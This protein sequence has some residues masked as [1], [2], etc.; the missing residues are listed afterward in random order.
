[1]LFAGA[2]GKAWCEAARRLNADR[3]FELQCFCNGPDGDVRDLNNRWS[4]AYGV[5]Q[6]GAVLI[7]PDGFIAWRARVPSD[8]E[9][10][11][12]SVFARLSFRSP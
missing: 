8:P 5:G 4:S 12:R 7:R 6:D 10:T 9:A 3:P 11:L 2:T 1:V